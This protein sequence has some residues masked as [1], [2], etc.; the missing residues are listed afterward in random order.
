[1]EVTV[2]ESP[3]LAVAVAEAAVAVAVSSA[4]AIA[5]GVFSGSAGDKHYE[6]NQLAASS[7]WNIVHNLDKWPSVT[8]VDSSKREVV[9]E[10][11]HL[12]TN[13]LTIRFSAPFSGRAYCN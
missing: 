6:H 1:M 9:G 5:V 8:V 12:T 7:T 10:I 2:N 13:T 4:A 3:V 11:E